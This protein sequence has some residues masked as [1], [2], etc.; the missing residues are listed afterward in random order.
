[1]IQKK[2]KEMNRNERKSKNGIEENWEEN[3]K[4]KGR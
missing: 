3:M 4:K 1:M 2:R